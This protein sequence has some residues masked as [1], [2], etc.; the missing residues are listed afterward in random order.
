MSTQFICFYGEI[1]K[2]CQQ[3]FVEKIV[4]S[5]AMVS[6]CLKGTFPKLKLIVSVETCPFYVLI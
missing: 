2:K 6:K 1:R 5:E 4:L 3:F